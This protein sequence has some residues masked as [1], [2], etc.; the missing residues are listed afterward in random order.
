MSSNNNYYNQLFGL[1]G[2]LGQ[3][4]G[5]SQW[6]LAP[7]HQVPPNITPPEAEPEF[8]LA[9]LTGDDDEA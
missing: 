2:A 6:A 8:N 1:Q 9:L 5:A 4:I 3:A 7:P